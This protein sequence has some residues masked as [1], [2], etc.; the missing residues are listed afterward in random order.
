MISQITPNTTAL[1]HVVVQNFR[2]SFGSTGAPGSPPSPLSMPASAWL[3]VPSG[4][5]QNSTVHQMV[6]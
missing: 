4:S 2:F 5:T 1:T 3:T 6:R